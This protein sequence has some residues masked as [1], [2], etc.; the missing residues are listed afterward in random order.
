METAVRC[1]VFS[2]AANNTRDEAEVIRPAPRA[3]Q[4]SVGQCSVV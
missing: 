2:G 1:Y 3:V 4:C